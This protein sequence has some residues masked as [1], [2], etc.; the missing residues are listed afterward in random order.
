MPLTLLDYERKAAAHYGEIC[1]NFERKGTPI[2]VND[3]HIA[4][5][6]RSERLTL[7][8]SNMREFECVEGLRI[9]K[10]DVRLGIASAAIE[11]GI[12]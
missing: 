9:D 10:L 6:A 2:G 11:D 12:P 3:L 8:T 1:I 7:L 4:G 5:H